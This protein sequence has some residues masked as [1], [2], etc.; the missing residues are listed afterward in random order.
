[1]IVTFREPEA[2]CPKVESCRGPFDAATLERLA[3][4]A[5]T[6]RTRELLTRLACQQRETEKKFPE[7]PLRGKSAPVIL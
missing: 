2:H 1:M 4:I 7:H 5:T 6:D 3:G